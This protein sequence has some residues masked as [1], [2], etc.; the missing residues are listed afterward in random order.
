MKLMERERED[1]RI[2]GDRI[3]LFVDAH[4]HIYDC[5]DVE[6]VLSSALRNFQI[7]ATRGQRE[8]GFTAALILTDSAGQEGFDRLQRHVGGADLCPTEEACSVRLDF[9][10]G[11][12]LFLIAGR[13]LL[14]IST[15]VLFLIFAPLLFFT[16][17]L[18][19]LGLSGGFREAFTKQ[20]SD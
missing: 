6:T 11:R 18:Y 8:D 19:E 4:V 7:E 3:M 14:F 1:Y 9:G 2:M 10:A 5:F 17:L 15:E 20:K 16:V 12:G 13:Q